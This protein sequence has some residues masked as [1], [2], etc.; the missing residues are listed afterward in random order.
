M[1]SFK[2]HNPCGA[3]NMMV[4]LMFLTP[5]LSLLFLLVLAIINLISKKKYYT[6]YE[7]ISLPFLFLIGIVLLIIF[8]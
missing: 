1:E 2:N 4:G 8:I 3:G 6:D 5:I 7:F